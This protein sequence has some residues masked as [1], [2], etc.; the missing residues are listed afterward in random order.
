MTS[1]SIE[2]INQQFPRSQN[3]DLNWVQENQM[4]PNVLWLAEAVSQVMDLKPGMRVLD[5]GCGKAISSIFLAKEFGLQVWAA[6]LWISPTENWQRILAAGLEEQVFPIHAEAHSLPFAEGFFD[7]A[8]S[9]DA[10]HYFGTNDM[11]YG[12]YFN[13]LLK[14]GGQLGI[15]VPGIREEI[16][17]V[18]PPEHLRPYWNWEYFTFHSPEWWQR[19]FKRTGM[20]EVEQADWLQDGWKHWLTWLEMRKASG[21]RYDDSE[22]EMLRVD[23][24]RTIGFSRVAARKIG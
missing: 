15:V 1:M 12:W 24:G 8:V 16:E 5:M 10:Y 14:P 4:G 23:A 21:Q 11:Y 6:D 3:Y 7:A 18:E 9:L 13:K 19:Q 2:E 20:L 17:G 22:T